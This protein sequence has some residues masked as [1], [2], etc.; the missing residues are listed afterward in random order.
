MRKR[1][2]TSKGRSRKL[3]R[4]TARPVVMNKKKNTGRGIKRGGT[5]M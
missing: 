3:F 2:K 1:W 4:K 5:R